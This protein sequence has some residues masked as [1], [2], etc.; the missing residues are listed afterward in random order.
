MF[1]DYLPILRRHYTNAGLVTVVC[2]CRCGL[3]SGCGKSSHIL[4]PA[5]VSGITC[6][7]SGGTTQTQ[8]WWLLCAVVDVGWSQD[9]GRQV[10]IAYYEIT[11]RW[12]TVNENIKFPFILYLLVFLLICANSE[13][14]LQH[15][16][17]RC[18]IVLVCTVALLPGRTEGLLLAQANKMT[19]TILNG[20]RIVKH[21][22]LFVHQISK[23]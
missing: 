11:S 7:S 12:H 4:R 1:R 2:G 15:Y 18:L 14:F 10:G 16:N 21:L 20:Q 22:P 6:P 3:V 13:M 5:H 19:W 23:H 8:G 9:V 17:D